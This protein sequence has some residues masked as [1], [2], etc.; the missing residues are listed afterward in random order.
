MSETFVQGLETDRAN[1][2]HMSFCT[3]SLMLGMPPKRSQTALNSF[4]MD[5]WVIKF[6]SHCQHVVVCT[7]TRDL[8]PAGLKKV[9]RNGFGCLVRILCV[10]HKTYNLC[11]RWTPPA[12]ADGSV[13]IIYTSHKRKG[14]ESCGYSAW[15]KKGSGEILLWP[16]NTWRGL[17]RKIRTYFLAGS[18]VT[19]QGVMI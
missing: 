10:A 5:N 17:G 19:G 1:G 14:W 4:C 13:D 12:K 18:V 16:F 7:S 11:I 2:K 8:L 15:R 6:F 3:G 9:K